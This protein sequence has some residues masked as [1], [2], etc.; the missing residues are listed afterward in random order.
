M[1][2]RILT[3]EEVDEIFNLKNII[4]PTIKKVVPRLISLEIIG[5]QP[6]SG[7]FDED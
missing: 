7:I 6:M 3:N 1:K 5:V 2:I 4:L